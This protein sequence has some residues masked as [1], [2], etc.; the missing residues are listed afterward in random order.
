MQVKCWNCIYCDKTLPDLEAVKSHESSCS[1]NIRNKKLVVCA[2]CDKEFDKPYKLMLHARKHKNDRPFQCSHCDVTFKS[3]SAK[4]LHEKNLHFGIRH[5]IK[6]KVYKCDN[7]GCG[8]DFKNI[9]SLKTHIDAVHLGLRY[10]CEECN[11]VFR[12]DDSLKKHLENWHSKCLVRLE[13]KHC[14]R[15][16]RNKTTY[17]A[18]LLKPRHLRKVKQFEKRFQKGKCTSV[19]VRQDEDEIKS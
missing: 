2:I 1:M 6:K 17:L 4:K 15:T 5:P 12:R 16:Y 19:S 18:H 3:G 13:C 8:R 11:K 7:E 9:T 10:P 14:K